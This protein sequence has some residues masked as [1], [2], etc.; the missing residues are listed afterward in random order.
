M[1]HRFATGAVRTGLQAALLA[2]CCASALAQYTGPSSVQLTTVQQLLDQGRDDQR[3]ILRGRLVQHDGG[4]HYTFA[5][6]SG[7][8][9]VEIDARLL[10]AG[11][12]F[13][14][15]QL[16]E[17]SGEYDKDL[18]SQEVEVDSLRLIP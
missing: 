7:R 2:M 3:V 17:V 18:M 15:K 10:P 11:Q 1:N 12:S 5:D 6:E 16:I 13:D 4:E 14:D 9:G 8:I